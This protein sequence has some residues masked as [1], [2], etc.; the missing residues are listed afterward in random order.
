MRSL[1]NSEN[2]E[3]KSFVYKLLIDKLFVDKLLTFM[4]T[5]IASQGR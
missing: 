4:E 5:T 2:G 3:L 1:L